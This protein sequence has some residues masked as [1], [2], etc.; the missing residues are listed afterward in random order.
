MVFLQ[1]LLAL[2]ISEKVIIKAPGASHI[3]DLICRARFSETCTV[4]VDWCG[5]QLV[6][7][8]DGSVFGLPTEWNACWEKLGV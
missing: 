2:L 7:N 4:R 6:L 3:D 5:R 1:R 8:A